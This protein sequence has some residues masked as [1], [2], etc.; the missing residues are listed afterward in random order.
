[1]LRAVISLI[2]TLPDSTAR[3]CLV[4]SLPLGHPRRAP[5]AGPVAGSPHALADVPLQG[6]W[7]PYSS[8]VQFIEGGFCVG[9][10]AVSRWMGKLST[11]GLLLLLWLP[12]PKEA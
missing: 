5:E 10:K 2:D 11:P 1:M 4:Q 3:D 12:R 9:T 7:G 8:R 6:G